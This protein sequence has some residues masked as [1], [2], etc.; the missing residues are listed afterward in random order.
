VEEVMQVQ[1]DTVY[2]SKT[3]RDI[4]QTNNKK[5]HDFNNFHMELE[6]QLL[7][8]KNKLYNSWDDNELVDNIIEIIPRAVFV[9]VQG[10]TKKQIEDCKRAKLIYQ[11]NL[12]T[13][14]DYTNKKE[15]ITR[16]SIKLMK[17]YLYQTSKEYRN[18]LIAINKLKAQGKITLDTLKHV[19]MT[20][21]RPSAYKSD[22][23]KIIK[24]LIIVNEQIKKDLGIEDFANWEIKKIKVDLLIIGGVKIL[25]F[26]K[27]KD[28]DIQEVKKQLKN[29]KFHLSQYVD[30]LGNEIKNQKKIL[31]NMINNEINNLGYKE[32][33]KE[34]STTQ[35]IFFNKIKNSDG[36]T[37]NA[38]TLS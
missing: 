29:L 11:K 5:I 36:I 21:N 16:S 12:K 24:N 23:R 37:E 31:G 4:I 3:I 30:V 17:Q 27:E 28:E 1:E 10:L 25:D 32:F 8:E 18:K 13:I 15:E 35:K 19:E 26:L 33:V 2:S 7:I 9:P 14:A 6:K 22:F 38:N 34:N 20:I